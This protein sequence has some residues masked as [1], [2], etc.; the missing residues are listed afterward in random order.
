VLLAAALGG[1]LINDELAATAGSPRAYWVGPLA[2]RQAELTSRANGWLYVRYVPLA[3]PRPSPGELLTV[4]T[5][6]GAG[7]IA[8]LERARGEKVNLQGGAV[9]LLP[10]DRQT[11]VYVAFPGSDVQV[12]VYD[13]SP[14]VARR[15]VLSGL[16]RP[17]P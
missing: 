2:G 10:S 17:V 9:V 14:A 11:S 12:E 3:G 7:G 15:L 4:A 6:P 13:P 16:V 8:A 1:W 5:Y